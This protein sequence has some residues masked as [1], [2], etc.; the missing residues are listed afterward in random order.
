MKKPYL[1]VMFLEEFYATADLSNFEALKDE[2]KA[3]QF[4]YRTTPAWFARR[5]RP[6]DI[7]V[8]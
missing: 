1:R 8:N 7:A 2:L 3:W 4:F 5:R 6:P